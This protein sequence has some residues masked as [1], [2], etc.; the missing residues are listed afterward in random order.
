MPKIQL[1]GTIIG[2]DEDM[3]QIIFYCPLCD[4]VVVIRDARFNYSFNNE[5]CVRCGQALDWTE[6]V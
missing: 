5:F 1:Y 3:E 2:E 6:T 4:E